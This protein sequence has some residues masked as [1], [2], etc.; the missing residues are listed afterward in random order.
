MGSSADRLHKEAKK[1]LKAKSAQPSLS[2]MCWS[3]RR[4]SRPIR[5]PARNDTSSKTT[6]RKAMID[7]RTP[8]SSAPASG[9]S[10]R[11]RS[12]QQIDGD[13]GRANGGAGTGRAGQG[14]RRRAGHDRE[15]IRA[16]RD[17]EARVA[18]EARPRTIPT[19]SIAL[20]L[21]LGVGA[22]ARPGSRRFRPR[23]VGQ[24]DRLR[25]GSWPRPRPGGVVAFTDCRHALDPGD[26]RACGVTRPS[27]SSASRTP[28]S[29]RSR[30]TETLIR[31]G[32]Y[33]LR[34]RRL[35][36]RAR[37]AGRDR[38]RDGRQLHGRPG[39]L[40]EPGSCAS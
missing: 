25:A 26:A 29:R 6:Y 7:R 40:D 36:G 37:A 35:G 13:D 33:R 2:P 8:S 17:H 11:T 14:G 12:V 31:S 34:R 9:R 5:K 24:D 39:R 38:G 28:A 20:D 21:A 22:L 3:D 4:T 23:V 30:V 16:R 1:K 27:S 18:R 32:G 19:G 15:A 10:D